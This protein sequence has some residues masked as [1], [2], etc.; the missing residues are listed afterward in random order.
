M[1]D[2]RNRIRML[3]EVVD[4]VRSVVPDT[5]PVLVRV[6]ATDWAAGGWISTRPSTLPKY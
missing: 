2:R 1:A 6:S 3:V 5:M 4:A